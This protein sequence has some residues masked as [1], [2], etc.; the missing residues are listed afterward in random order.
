M[1]VHVSQGDIE[2]GEIGSSR[3]CPLARAIGRHMPGSYMTSITPYSVWMY[4]KGCS[5]DTY[6]YAGLP[7]HVAAFVKAFDAGDTVKPFDFELE[8]R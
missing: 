3:T 6:M 8:L 5:H 1:I 2:I 4:K 7:D